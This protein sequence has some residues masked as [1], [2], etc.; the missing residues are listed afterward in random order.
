MS[1]S[2][3]SAPGASQGPVAEPF[4]ETRPTRPRLAWP[5]AGSLAVLLLDQLTKWIV[6]ERLGPGKSQHRWGIVEPALAFEYVENTGAAFGVFRGQG[7]LLT[8]LSALVL[9][10]LLAYYLTVREPSTALMAGICLLLGGAAGNLV[11]RVRLGYVV[12]FAAVGR[13]PK[14]NLAD[15]AISVGVVLLAWHLIVDP[16]GS[17]RPTGD[18]DWS[19]ASESP[20][21]ATPRPGRG[22]ENE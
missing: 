12:D 21:S 18:S 1:A 19:S 15:S 16:T 14:F 13:W 17:V 2:K 9:I 4:G 5:L 8:A 20:P 7:T 22:H 6:V 11:D 10:G 3:P